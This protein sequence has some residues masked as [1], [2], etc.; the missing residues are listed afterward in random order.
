[1]NIRGLLR[2]SADRLAVAGIGEAEIEAVFLLCHVL[3][4]SRAQLFLNDGQEVSSAQLELFEA[5]LSR[6]LAREPLA[7]ILGEQEFWSLPFQVS[8]DVLIPRPET[9]EL[10]ERVFAVVVREGLPPGPLL[11]LGVGSGA[12]AV[13]LAKELPGRVVFAVDYSLAA[14][15]TAAKNRDRH[16]VGHRLFLLNADWLSAIKEEGLF[17]L[18]VSNPPYIAGGVMDSLQPEVRR[19]EPY[20]ALASGCDGLDAIRILADR[21]H[22]H[23]K[24]GGYL[25][26]EIGFDQGD[27]VL[28]IFSAKNA[29]ASVCVHPDLAGLPRIL[30]VQRK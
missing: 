20:I 15:R 21:V 7:Y 13:V 22:Y 19:F 3:D 14:L 2:V 25:F 30:Q 1:M 27:A 8:P 9:E 6:R 10:L 16:G 28:D 26:M 12:I 24:S 29:Y 23:L 4:C 5:L 18:I 11:D 17:S